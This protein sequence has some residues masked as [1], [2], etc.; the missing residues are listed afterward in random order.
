M[1]VWALVSPARLCLALRLAL[2]LLRS[3][4]CCCNASVPY[5]LCIGTN[6]LPSVSS[7]EFYIPVP[8]V[9]HCGSAP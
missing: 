3:L 4:L 1:R 7:V 9:R 8:S 6:A 5:R 2:L